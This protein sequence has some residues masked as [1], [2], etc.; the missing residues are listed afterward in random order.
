MFHSVRILAFLL[1]MSSS[2][3]SAFAESV[4]VKDSFTTNDFVRKIGDRLHTQAPEQG[5]ADTRWRVTSGVNSTVFSSEGTII[6]A[7]DNT[8]SEARIAIPAPQT[9]ITVSARVSAST[10]DWVG[11]G[12]LPSADDGNWLSKGETGALVWLLFRPSGSWTLFSEGTSRQLLAGGP[13]NY[14]AILFKADAPYEIG[15]SYDP[16]IRKARPFVRDGATEINLFPRDGG[17]IDTRLPESAI[18]KATGFRINGR[19]GSISGKAWVDDFLVTE[20]EA[21]VARFTQVPETIRKRIPVGTPRK[22]SEVEASPFGIH[23]TIFHEGGGQSPQFIERIAGLVSEGGFKWVVDYIGSGRTGDMT[24]EEVERK[25]ARLP[26]RCFQYADLLRRADVNL[27]LRIDPMPWAPRGREAEF[28]YSPDSDNMRKSLAFVRLTVRQLKPYTRHWQIWNEPNLGNATPFISP[29]NYVKV[30][31]QVAQ[32]IREEQPDAILYGPG[33]A[34]LQCLAD[35]PYPWISKVLEA[36]LLDHVNVFTFHPYRQPAVR[37]NLPENASEFYPWQIWKTYEN[38]IADLKERLRKH[39]KN[40]AD[41]PLAT[42]EDGLPDLINGAGEQQISWIVG[43]KY[44]LRRALLDVWLNIS[45]RT[46][47]CLYRP[48]PDIFYHEQSS[49]SIVTADFQKKPV[50]NAAQN[51]NAVLDSSYARTNDVPVTI[52]PAGKDSAAPKGK[53]QI[54]TYLKDYGDFEELLVFY[55]SAEISSDT[56]ARYP[57]ALSIDQ[58]GWEAPLFID[59]M[60]MPVRRPKASP[61]EII[62]SKFVDRRDPEILSARFTQTGVAINHLEIRDYPLLVK[63]VRRK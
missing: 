35:T 22:P 40:S 49:Y 51:L 5:G 61:V 21:G 27:L 63:W 60:S 15:V 47:F 30:F 18:I 7:G 9:I 16:A 45:P 44:E 46:L 8:S 36:G 25:F 54:Q 34:M 4:L 1:A 38:Q 42:T 37:E 55:W 53:L 56:H 48:I 17:W 33:T 32:V 57:A 31:R 3:L 59:L 50:F 24:V 28:D 12:F 39:S 10:A 43:A 41:F 13:S 26:E 23:T 11:V 29:E 14:P 19:T 20:A 52:M 2:L 6:T 58:P 62:D